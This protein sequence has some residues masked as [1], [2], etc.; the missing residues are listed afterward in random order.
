MR[1]YWEVARRAFRRY[2][3]YRTATYAGIFTNAIFGLIQAYVLLAVYRRRADVTTHD[4]ADIQRLCRRVLII[5]RGR[6]IFD[7][8]LD[9]ITERFGGERT[10]V[11]DLQE[12][13]PPLEVE[14]AVVERVDGPRQWLRF[15]RSE[16]TA[17]QLVAEVASR[18]GLVD[19]AVEEP[20]IDE[21]VRRIYTDGELPPRG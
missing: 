19:L 7:G 3:T 10:L 13:A 5:D 11:V 21:I 17:A 4:L 9:E 15:R 18:G 2:A 14:G 8:S 6:V 20:D 16:V 1:L 12:S